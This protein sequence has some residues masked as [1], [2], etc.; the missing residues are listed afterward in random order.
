[1]NARRLIIA[2]TVVTAAAT[3]VWFLKP[4][5]SPPA[6]S[7]T[8][9]VS[10]A[11]PAAPPAPTSAACAFSKGAT[12]AFSYRTQTHYTV[13]A[14]IPGAPETVPQLGSAEL[15]G[16]LSF[17]V[18]SVGPE[19]ATVLGRLSEVNE[20]GQKR[21]GET[22]GNAFLAQVDR[23]CE[24]KAFARL[25]GTPD[26]AARAQQVVLG[27]LSFSVGDGTPVSET[28]FLTGVGTQRALVARG[29]DGPDHFVRQPLKYLS[30]WSTRMQGVEFTGGRVDVHRGASTWFERIDGIEE[31]AG[32]QVETSK[33]EWKVE[34]AEFDAVALKGASRNQDDYVWGNALPLDE[35]PEQSALGSPSEDHAKRVELARGVTFE[36]AMGRFSVMLS[37]G[38][39]VNDQWRDV[40]AFLDAHPEEIDDY[41]D[42][43]TDEAFP[44]GGKAPAFLALGQAQ[45]PQARE[46]LLGIYRQR[47]NGIGDR[48]RSS[49][50]LAGRLDVGVPL[51]KELRAEAMRQPTDPGEAA[52]SRQALLHLGVMAGS[53]PAQRDVVEQATEVVQSLITSAR[54]ED[55]YSVMCGMVGNMAELALL[56]QIETW[57]R[58]PDPALRKKVPQ[59]IRRYQVDRVHELVVDWLTRETN[60]DVKRELFNVLHHMYVDANKPI[61]EALKREAVRHLREAP[62]PLTRQSLYHLLA[63]HVSDPEVHQLFKAQLKLELAEKSGLYSLVAS[64]LPNQSIFEV[65]AGVDGLQ[66]QFGGAVKPTTA[67]TPPT[68]AQP[69]IPIRPSAAMEAAT[70]SSP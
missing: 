30:R 33:T 44:P 19:F 58:L 14:Q 28:S 66:H 17:E 23:R 20:E 63:P 56:P 48:I 49:L 7:T 8:A 37:S 53:R 25:K 36:Q 31:L 57:T 51:A 5:S 55:D 35:Q 62:L 26:V 12:F 2:A 45:A 67:P 27:D 16:K 68:S 50:A 54:T 65:L 47:E 29:D 32:G 60:A 43:I 69:E 4:G 59:A 6:G 42:L 3:L 46:A 9:P 15:F 52:V 64:Y 39:N 18:L 41:A 61:D 70:R 13:L 34:P 22:L 1:V 10:A 40:A 24:V 38:A 11:L 21:A